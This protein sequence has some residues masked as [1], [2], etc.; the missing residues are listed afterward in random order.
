VPTPDVVYD[1]AYDLDLGGRTV[2][3]RPTAEATPRAT[4]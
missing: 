3:L 2:A 4:R 1:D